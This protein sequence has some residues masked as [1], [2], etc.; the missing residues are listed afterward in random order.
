MQSFVKKKKFFFI[1]HQSGVHSPSSKRN[2]KKNI[3]NI[4]KVSLKK[5][6]FFYLIL[7]D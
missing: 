2:L 3:R 1:T 4:S 6:V 7:T 5:I